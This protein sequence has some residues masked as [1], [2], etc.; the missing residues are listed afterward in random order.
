LRLL[1]AWLVGMARKTVIVH[2][3]DKMQRGYTYV[4]TARRFV[5]GVTAASRNTRYQAALANHR[6]S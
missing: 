4:L 2:V 6:P 3:N 1:K 5:F